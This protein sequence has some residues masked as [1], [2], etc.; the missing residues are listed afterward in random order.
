LDPFHEERLH[1]D[2]RFLCFFAGVFRK[3]KTQNVS[4]ELSPGAHEKKLK[5]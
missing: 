5:K 3:G 4:W 1:H 2:C